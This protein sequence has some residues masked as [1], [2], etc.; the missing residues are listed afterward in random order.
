MLDHVK[1]PTITEKD[2]QHQNQVGKKIW[3][4]VYQ[5]FI[6]ALMLQHSQS[7]DKLLFHNKLQ[8]CLND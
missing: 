1:N 3:L 5:Q 2:M 7:E 4:H 6:E 8:S